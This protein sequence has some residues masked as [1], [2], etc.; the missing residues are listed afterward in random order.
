METDDTSLETSYIIH[1]S[2]MP[3]FLRL[4]VIEIVLAAFF[5][6]T[7]ILIVFL[8]FIFNSPYETLYW[9]LIFVL[10]LIQ[11]AGS[12]YLMYT[13]INWMNEFYILKP[14]SII[15]KQGVF[16]TREDIFSAPMIKVVEVRQAYLGQLF[17]Y[18]DVALSESLGGEEF[19]L[20]GIPQPY[21]FEQIIKKFN[22]NFEPLITQIP[23]ISDDDITE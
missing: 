16:S 5:Y 3:I 7:G 13:T 1:K 2:I 11:L 4:I 10:V 23:T 20:K 12:C 8:R 22:Q 6:L 9:W 19:V 14:A 21:K 17:D 18:G 15:R